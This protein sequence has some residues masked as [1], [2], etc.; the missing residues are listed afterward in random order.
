[1]KC[2]VQVPT[3]LRRPHVLN[4]V[5]GA[6]RILDIL[7]IGDLVPFK[8]AVS[9]EPFFV[10]NYFPIASIPDRTGPANGVLRCQGRRTETGPKNFEL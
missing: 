2:E 4:T 8:F 10:L 7:E 5:D 9:T 3:C 1:M 6:R